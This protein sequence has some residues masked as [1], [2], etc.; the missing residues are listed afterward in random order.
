M[1][2]PLERLV[3]DPG[4]CPL[5]LCD[6]SLLQADAPCPPLPSPDRLAVWLSVCLSDCPFPVAGRGLNGRRLCRRLDGGGAALPQPPGSA[7]LRTA[8]R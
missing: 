5:P 7:R 8:Q 1:P 6:G 2:P 3:P 4:K